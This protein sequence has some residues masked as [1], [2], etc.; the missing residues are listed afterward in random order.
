MSSSKSNLQKVWKKRIFWLLSA[1]VIERIDSSPWVSPIVVTRKKT[2][3]IRMCVD[4]REP[5]KAIIIDSHPLPHMEELLSTLT[6]ATVFSTIYL[7]SAYHQLTLHPDSRDLTAFI[8]HEGLFRFC[9]VPYGLASEPAAFQ[10]LMATVLRGVPNVQNYL[11]DIICYGRTAQLHDTALE[12]VLQRLKKAGL[13]LN[14]KKC[15][16]RQSSLK[17]LGHLVTAAD[18]D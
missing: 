3:G 15:H 1:G 5:N 10:K 12:T 16:F 13:Q 2:R 8:T 18:G 17:F 4:L 11:D 9:R 7:E 14:E 6:G